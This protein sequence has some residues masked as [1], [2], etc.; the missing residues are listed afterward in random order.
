MFHK[1]ENTL[2][3]KS[4][5]KNLKLSVVIPITKMAGK[6]SNLTSTLEMCPKEEIELIL[7]HDEQDLLTQGELEN[8]KK[9]FDNLD[10]Q[11]FRKTFQS[12]GLARNYGI[13][14]STGDWFCF[15]D[16]DDLPQI[17]KI[18]E[19]AK[20]ANEFGAD[21][22]IGK[23]VTIDSKKISHINSHNLP[24]GNNLVGVA[25]ALNPGFTRFVFK[26]SVFKQVEFPRITM[27]EDQVYLARTS[28]LN[29]KIY[30]SSSI[31][32]KYFVD[33]PSQATK[34]RNSLQELPLAL[35]LLWESKYGSSKI[36]N[37][38]I[39]FQIMKISLTCIS[40][41]IERR[42]AAKN[43]LSISIKNPLDAIY[44]CRLLLKAKNG[45]RN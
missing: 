4:N 22:G 29:Y 13:L 24:S 7:V 26:S 25:L 12:P 20:L 3:M 32:Y 30:S 19:T 5:K 21:V 39:N 36:M 31:L 27:G 18:Y 43:L 28:F 33:V 35:Q 8:L 34:N 15:S 1:V 38:F 14:K 17:Y 10:I 9:R 40:H 6:L 11:V 2:Y 41:K 23:L 16:S 44:F 45:K 37:Q 42:T